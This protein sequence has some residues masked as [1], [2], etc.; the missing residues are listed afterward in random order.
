M[1][2]PFEEQ[3]VND[4]GRIVGIPK[5]NFQILIGTIQIIPKHQSQHVLKALHDFLLS[6]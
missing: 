4:T 1:Y 5:H 3:E 2:G 6:R